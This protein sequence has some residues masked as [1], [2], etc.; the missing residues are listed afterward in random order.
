MKAKDNLEKLIKIS[1]HW[2]LWFAY[3]RESFR[4]YYG[5]PA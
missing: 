4:N 2:Q 3:E 5:R 1:A